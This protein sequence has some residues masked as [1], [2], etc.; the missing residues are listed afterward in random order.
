MTDRNKT[1]LAFI[2][3]RSGSMASIREAMIVGFNAFCADQQKLPGQ[4][5]VSLYQFDNEY[6]VVYE[7]RPLDAATMQLEPRGYTALYDAVGRSIRLIGERLARKPEHERPASVVVVIITDGHENASKEM[8]YEHVAVTMKEHET[9]Y[10]WRFA[11][12]GSK[13]LADAQRMGIA[14]QS[15]GAY[16]A[17]ASGVRS[18][19]RN[20]GQAITSYRSDVADGDDNAVLDISGTDNDPDPDAD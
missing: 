9:K 15:M 16:V 3:D 5:T 10:N 14:T 6:D 11:F 2:V 18:M 12:M 1:E 19:Y 13:G 7:E 8:S 17:S 20:I 4:C